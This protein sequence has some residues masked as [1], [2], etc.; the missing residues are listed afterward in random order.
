M[1][2][3]NITE[4]IIKYEYQ[5][6]HYTSQSVAKNHYTIYATYVPQEGRLSCETNIII[7]NNSTANWDELYLHLYP[8][9][10]NN[11]KWDK[12]AKPLKAGYI[13][14][15]KL[16]LNNRNV[17]YEVD[18]TIL[19]ITLPKPLSFNESAKLKIDFQLFLPQGGLRLFQKGS[20]AFLAQWYPI[21]AVYDEKGWHT[22]PYTNIG[23]PFYT[24]VSDYDVYLQV[25]KNFNVISSAEDDTD[26]IYSVLTT[27]EKENA[28][29]T[30][31]LKQE[32]IRDFA[33]VISEEFNLKKV[34]ENN[35]EINLWYPL[36]LK[37][38]EQDL[39]TLL[40]VAKQ[41][42]NFYSEKIASYPLSELDIILADTGYGTLGMEYPGLVTSEMYYVNK[43]GEKT[44]AKNV[45]AHEIAHQ[46]W[47]SSV[48]N[49]QVHEAWLDEGLTTFF[50]YWFMQEKLQEYDLERVQKGLAQIKKESDEVIKTQK[51][52]VLQSVYQ[53]PDYYGLFVYGRAAAMLWE[54]K[55]KFGDTTLEKILQTYYQRYQN[56]VATTSDF[57]QIANEVTGQNLTNYFA[58]WLNISPLNLLKK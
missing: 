2:N 41:S 46:W 49:D 23:D 29:K 52:S 5:S 19:K 24:I 25:P 10:F 50:E 34:L 56:K 45:V 54:L 9:A 22:D 44:L 33:V 8:N 58:E 37:N 14:I 53:Y 20:T 43:S 11:W 13:K 26:S 18:N 48:G 42:L 57:I 17:K 7:P 31:Y 38:N 6:N 4:P 15:E 28:Y 1:E 47:Y 3:N 12:K 51:I 55:T 30:V 21:V 40:N 39:Q 32:N 16:E 27:D 36:E 35:T